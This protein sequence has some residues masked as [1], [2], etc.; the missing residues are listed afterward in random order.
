MRTIRALLLLLVTGLGVSACGEEYTYDQAS[1]FPQ[2]WESSY[3]KVVNCK[4]S[5]IHSG[6][7]VAV[8]ADSS[9]VDLYKGDDKAVAAP[10]GTVIVKPQYSD[11]G[12]TDLT[13]ITVMRKGSPGT[14]PEKGDWEYQNITGEGEIAEEGQV[15]YCINC[16]T[17]CSGKDY[18]CD[19]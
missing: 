14:A 5:A 19:R 11:D 6:P 4:K 13:A 2:D 9:G 16:H 3:T 8:W 17:G 15:G 10:E 1:F 7:Y 12:C 18:L